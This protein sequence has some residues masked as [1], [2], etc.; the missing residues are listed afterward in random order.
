MAGDTVELFDGTNGVIH[1]LARYGQGD[2]QT[3]TEH[4]PDDDVAK[5][6]GDTGSVGGSASA[7]VAHSA[8]TP[9][10]DNSRF[11]KRW[12]YCVRWLSNAPSCGA[13]CWVNCSLCRRSP[14][15][16]GSSPNAT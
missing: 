13:N 3:N 2:A 6:F 10:A 9:S 12:T 8:Q 4:D 16:S 11:C 7:R 1:E 15:L 14:T 5:G